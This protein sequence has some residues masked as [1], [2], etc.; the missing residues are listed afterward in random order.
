MS[1]EVP[2]SDMIVMTSMIELESLFGPFYDEYFNGENKV[3]SKSS[4]VTTAG[5]SDKRQQQP[6]S[7]SS[8]STLATTVTADGNFDMEKMPTKIELTLEQSQQGVSNDVL[9]SIEEKI[10]EHAYDSDC[11]DEAIANAIF[12]ANLSPIGSLND[13]TVEPHYNSNMLSKSYDELT[14]N[15]KVISCTDYMLTIG[16]DEDNYV[17]P[18]IQKNDMMLSVI[19]QIKSQVEKCNMVNQESKSMNES[20]TNELER[21]KDRVRVLEYAVKD[22]HSE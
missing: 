3:V 4:A 13:D 16:N 2:T 11:D 14:S 15:S 12:M 1:I 5:T 20:L 21:Y 19:E 9:V 8:T 17:P 6:D 7:T 22:G 10:K 18:P